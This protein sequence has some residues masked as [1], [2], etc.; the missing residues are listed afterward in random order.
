MNDEERILEILGFAYKLGWT[1][2]HPDYLLRIM[3]RSEIEKCMLAMVD[4][5]ELERMRT[6]AKEKDARA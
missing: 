2:K 3:Q 5:A 6:W 1:A 4:D